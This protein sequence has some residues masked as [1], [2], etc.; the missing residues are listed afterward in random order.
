VRLFAVQA[1]WIYASD[2]VIGNEGDGAV[3]VCGHFNEAVHMRQ[4]L[5]RF[6]W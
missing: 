4:A 3:M 5:K 6:G 1:V 2:R